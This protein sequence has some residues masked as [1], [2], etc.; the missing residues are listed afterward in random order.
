M[1][2]AEEVVINGLGHAHD[3][4][5]VARFLHVFADFITGVH[6]VVAAIVEKVANVVFLE[7]LQNTLIIG[8]IQ[9]RVLHLITAGAQGG[10]RSIFQ[11]FQLG[12]VFLAH[13]EQPV[14]Q[15]AFDAVLRAQNAG[16]V[17]VFQSGADDAV[18]AGVDY[19]SGAAG[20]TDNQGAL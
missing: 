16:D 4:A 14:V 18:G 1:V 13:V 17:G 7:N 3:T 9:I 8:V 6:G 5:L 2:G 19:G 20:L 15:H 11:Q 10:R 12:G